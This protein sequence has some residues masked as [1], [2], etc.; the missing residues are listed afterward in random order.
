MSTH[1][2][3]TLIMDG[4]YLGYQA[5]FAMRGLDT[6]A[7]ES[8]PTAHIMFAFLSRVL[9]FGQMFCT[10]K[11]VFCWDSVES[12]RKAILPGYKAHRGDALTDAQREGRAETKRQMH[13]L[14]QEVLPEIGFYNNFCV[15]GYEADDLIAQ[16]VTEIID[17]DS[18][19]ISADEDLFQLLRAD[20]KMYTPSRHAMVTAASFKEEYGISP[21]QW[22]QAKSIA[23][24]DTDEVPGVAGVGIKTAIK[25]ILNTL[26]PKSKA[27][28][29]ITTEGVDAMA[30]RNVRLVSLPMEGTPY[31]HIGADDLSLDSFK[32]ICTRY[33]FHSFLEPNRL[34]EWR[35]FFEGDF[36]TVANTVVRR[37]KD[38]AGVG[39][40]PATLL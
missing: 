4:P 31:L 3:S 12:K 24:C 39:K 16:A 22:V 5:F 34:A 32:K 38:R 6:D 29:A 2:A 10:N 8:P 21:T 30:V 28:A 35:R 40:G 20:T 26:S 33:A 27:Y 18:I 37:I 7:N 15:R 23:G 36:S 11:I 19:L 13:V 14:R 25:Y 9:S 1:S 17:G